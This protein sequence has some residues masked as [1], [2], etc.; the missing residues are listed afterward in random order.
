[1][2]CFEGIKL[3]PPQHTHNLGGRGVRVWLPLKPSANSFVEMERQNIREDFRTTL[4]KYLKCR[5][6]A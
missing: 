1:M 6:I 2:P 5:V 4:G 3:P